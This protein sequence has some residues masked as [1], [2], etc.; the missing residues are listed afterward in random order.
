MHLT[1]TCAKHQYSSS[2]C[3][4]A[5]F[6]GERHVTILNITKTFSHAWTDA[7]R[8][9][10]TH[11]CKYF[12]AFKFHLVF[13]VFPCWV[14]VNRMLYYEFVRPSWNRFFQEFGFTQTHHRDV[15]SAIRGFLFHLLFSEKR[16]F[17][18]LAGCVLCYGTLG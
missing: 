4:R 3:V 12:N 11:T 13:L 16:R 8:K 6:H 10:S 15:G 2:Q 17:I 1:P 18:W 5:L 9:F 7:Y 14:G